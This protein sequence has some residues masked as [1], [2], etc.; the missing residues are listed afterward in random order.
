MDMPGLEPGPDGSEVS[1]H[2]ALPPLGME[3]QR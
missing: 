2:A 1:H 3:V